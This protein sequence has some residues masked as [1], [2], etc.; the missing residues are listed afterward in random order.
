MQRSRTDWHRSRSL[1]QARRDALGSVPSQHEA[2]VFSSSG[3]H[4]PLAALALIALGAFTT[5]CVAQGR[6]SEKGMV[7]QTVGPTIV[8][9]VYYR[10]VARGRD[11]LIGGVVPMGHRWTPGANWATTVEVDQ[12]VM[13]EGKLLPKGKYSLWAEP[14]PDSWT[15]ELHRKWN[16]FHLPAPDSSDEQLRFTVH[17]ETGPRTD[18]LTFD[19][20]DMG[21][22]TTTLR[23]RWGT[24]VVP[25]HL[26]MIAP[27]LKMLQSREERARYVGRYDLDI[28][29]MGGFPSRTLLVDILD[30]RDT[31][32]WKDASGS[33]ERRRDFVLSPAGDNEFTRATRSP[34][35]QYWTESGVTVSFQPA[36]G[37]A[38][39]FEVSIEDG[40]VASRAKRVP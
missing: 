22:G 32:H 9:V 2:P 11:S 8:T 7:A 25:I 13:V 21:V 33:E 17:P 15:F 38:N 3:R 35:G 23:L 31:L 36:S 29:P 16:R 6:L 14:H 39:G 19:F 27:P 20:P 5:P 24:T 34:Q 30:V 37:R 18:V 28:F 26:A 1:D 10:P 4:N 40:T 12:D